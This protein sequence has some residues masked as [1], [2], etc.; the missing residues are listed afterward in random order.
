[1]LILA[2][3]ISIKTALKGKW[4]S[5]GKLLPGNYSSCTKLIRFNFKSAIFIAEHMS[6]LSKNSWQKPY[7]SPTKETSIC[8]CVTTIEK[9][10]LL[11]W[12]PMKITIDPKFSSLSLMHSSHQVFYAENL[13]LVVF[14]RMNPLAVKINSCYWWSI[15]P[16]D[17]AIWI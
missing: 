10:I 12:M 17:Y 9:S 4:M 6:F 8:C 16:T 13:R 2:K 3:V 14:I 7:Y 11:F 5:Y 15:I 1:M